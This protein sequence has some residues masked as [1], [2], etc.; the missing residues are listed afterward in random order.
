MAKRKVVD[1]FLPKEKETAVIFQ[2]LHKKK[3]LAQETIKEVRPAR[4]EES[5][6]N[7]K[8]LPV[9]LLLILFSA[10]GFYYFNLAKA[11]ITIW[12]KTQDVN[13][14]TKLTV[15]KGVGSLNFIEKIIPGEI[16]EKEKV[17]T[18]TISSTGEIGKED[19]AEGIIKVYNEYSDSTQILIVNTRFVSTNG[20]VFRSAA[21]V[22]V[23]GFTY[24]DKNK[25]VPGSIDIKVIADQ[26]GPDYNIAPSTFSIPGFAG[27]E[28]YTKFYGKSLQPMTGGSSEKVSQVT[29]EDLDNAKIALSKRAKQECESLSIEELKMKETDEDPAKR[30]LFSEDAIQTDVIETFSLATP[31]MEADTFSYTAKAKSQTII[32]KESYMTSFTEEFVLSQFPQGNNISKKSTTVKI[33]PENV[34]LNLGKLILSLDISTKVY[35][36]FDL[37]RAK[38]ELKGKSAMES[39]VLLE[40]A[41]EVSRVEVKLWPFWVRKIPDD[42]EKI[43]IDL[44]VD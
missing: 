44:S 39:K 1:I 35:T 11:T 36:D 8:W 28:K 22:V 19:K 42:L 7:K 26:A 40:N 29:K 27:S 31:G 43:K 30:Y 3:E 24:D 32:F 4:K 17:V 10:G 37:S 34:N 9:F 6:G 2:N 41:P 23:P 14:A 16:F 38:E 20:K 13:V 21:R 15:D 25:M 33:M 18:E 12:P 5:G